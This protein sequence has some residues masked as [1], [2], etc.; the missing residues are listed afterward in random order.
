MTIR[1]IASVLC[2][3]AVVPL[4]LAQTS[5]TLPGAGM[6][7]EVYDLTPAQPALDRP[8]TVD[9][10]S[11]VTVTLIGRSSTLNISLVDPSGTSHSLGVTD[12]VVART[13][14]FDFST[15]GAGPW[16]YLF[17]LTNPPPGVWRYR[18]SDS[19]TLTGP[20]A[21]VFMLVTSSPVVVNLLGGGQDYPANQDIGISLVVVDGKAPIKGS[22][23]A[24]VSAAV[25]ASSGVSMPVNFADDGKGFDHT[26][27]DGIYS[28]T[29]R[30]SQADAYTL[31]VTIT[32]TTGSGGFVRSA[33]TA[34]RVVTPTASLASSAQSVPVDLNNNSLPD[35]LDVL[36]NVTTT[37]KGDFLLFA[38]LSSSNAS[39]VSET[40]TFSVPGAGTSQQSVRFSVADLNTLGSNGP[41][42]IS[43][44][45]LEQIMPDG[46]TQI[47]NTK[48]NLGQTVPIDLSRLERP[49]VILNGKNTDA[50]VDTNSNG[51]FDRLDVKVGA[52]VLAAGSYRWSAS[53]FAA[54][55]IQVGSA[56]GSGNL[57]AGAATVPLSFDGASL[58]KAGID[59]P[60]AVRSV[61]VTGSGQT[62]T[63]G[64]AGNT[65]AY[66]FDQF[67]G[68]PA[69][70]P[71]NAILNGASFLAGAVA[72]GQ[73]VS[74]FGKNL[75]P[76][77]GVGLQFASGS[78]NVI[79]ANLSGVVVTFNGIPAPLFFVR[80]DQI[81][82]QVPIE[83]D[84]QT[85][86]TMTVYYHNQVV[87]G[88]TVP[89]VPVAP[90]IFTVA[91][92]KGMAAM[93]N[94]DGS[95]HS[96]S[97]PAAP[98]SVIQIYMTG[99][100]VVSPPLA[101]GQ[102]VPPTA[103]FPAAMF[104]VTVTI[105]G[106]SAEVKFAG[107]APSLVGL[108]QVNAVVP[109]GA[110]PGAS[111]PLTIAIG[112]AS[113]QAGVTIAV[114]GTAGQ[115]TPVLLQV[116]GGTYNQSVGFGSTGQTAAAFVN[117]LTPAKYPATLQNVQIYFGNRKTGLPVNTS[118][119][120]IYGANPSGSAN[121]TTSFT[122]VPAKVNSTGAFNTYT[123]TT[124]IT[125]TSGDFI[126]GFIV[127]NPTGIYP[128]ELDTST[129]SQGRS[130]YAAGASN[131]VLLD[132]VSLPGNLAIRA[133][134]TQ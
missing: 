23:V 121:F 81:N 4:C 117:R 41:Y 133:T 6:Y 71:S 3:M 74:I 66:R 80:S 5:I 42:Q 57:P 79:S 119:T 52:D 58:G 29:F 26:A 27:N 115:P 40:S 62:S 35:G 128:A 22:S 14:S 94:Q 104:P 110:A 130:Y 1:R 120:V 78:T 97:N 129:P 127:D 38:T 85:T 112:S 31:G 116:D 84:G 10:A 83:L 122:S 47:S 109:P 12:A 102:L 106:L 48:A 123:A 108:F 19:A 64:A 125:I 46:T 73:V 54:N 60:Y 17:A 75:G 59:G 82:C 90:S 132:S 51:L 63:L 7:R 9:S 39:S 49:S 113:S 88:A 20:R 99:Q 69:R 55:R 131:F 126:V 2:G 87:T 114:K 25:T 45:R 43:T 8:F 24:S 67:E 56:T 16:N 124:P 70:L 101:N 13:S 98:G 105:G 30:L 28:A 50:G 36:V 134:V 77:T 72:P 32:G 118:I 111:V 37:S 92:G 91:G 96:V 11:N 61:V 100:G 15:T 89:V 95:V 76:A 33:S 53:L 107:M 68:A 44:I 86:A 34:F 65:G 103:P 21:I 18:V 93:F